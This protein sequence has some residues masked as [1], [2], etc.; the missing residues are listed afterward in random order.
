[1]LCLCLFSLNLL[2]RHNA[3]RSMMIKRLEQH[4]FAQ[5]HISC[6][7]SVHSGMGSGYKPVK[8][9]SQ[10]S[11]EQIRTCS[12]RECEAQGI[13]S[14]QHLCL[15]LSAWTTDARYLYYLPIT[16]H[17]AASQTS[18]LNFHRGDLTAGIPPCTWTI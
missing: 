5:C 4:G 17:S 15:Q 13:L 6:C 7:S 2:R 18:L 14:Q 11:S 8:K 12:F 9:T 10:N 1:M 3:R 16:A